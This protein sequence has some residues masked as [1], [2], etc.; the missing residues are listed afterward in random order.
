MIKEE[1]A[2]DKHNEIWE[3]VS[4]IS[5]KEFNNELVYNEKHLK[6]VKKRKI[7]CTCAQVILIDSVYR[8]DENYY[9]EEFLS[10]HKLITIEEKMPILND[11]VEFYSNDSDEEYC[12]DSHYS[13]EENSNRKSRMNKI[14]CINLFKKKIRKIW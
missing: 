2:F 5:E 8:K 3:K 1:K 11:D 13:D 10:K 12:N 14:S 9:P 7:N 4:N 6:A